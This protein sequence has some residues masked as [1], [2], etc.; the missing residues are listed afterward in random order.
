MVATETQ[1]THVWLERS[2]TD[3]IGMHTSSLICL[4]FL[5]T[6]VTAQQ[7]CPIKPHPGS[8]SINANFVVERAPGFPFTSLHTPER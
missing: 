6:R 4:F 7:I 8:T 5:N 1:S 2:L 3:A